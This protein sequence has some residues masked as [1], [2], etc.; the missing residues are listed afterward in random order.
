VSVEGGNSGCS[1]RIS[2]SMG[3]IVMSP[4]SGLSL[5][6]RSAGGM[7]SRGYDP[8]T[9]IGKSL[10]L[11]SSWL[12]IPVRKIPSLETLEFSCLQSERS[13]IAHPRQLTQLGLRWN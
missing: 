8:G 10:T 3:K 12:T 7:M 5:L 6:C 13:Q 2:D 4:M 11:C 1:L 9:S